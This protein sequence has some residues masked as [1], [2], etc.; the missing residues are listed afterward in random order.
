MVLND[1]VVIARVKHPI[2]SRTAAV[3]AGEITFDE[4]GMRELARSVLRGALFK[5][6]LISFLRSFRPSFKQ[7]KSS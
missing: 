1:L 6:R 2:P 4:S 7:R 3:K 5:L